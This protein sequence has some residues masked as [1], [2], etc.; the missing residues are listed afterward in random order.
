M[1]IIAIEIL[2]REIIGDPEMSGI[3]VFS[4]VCKLIYT[5][6]YLMVNSLCIKNGYSEC[7]FIF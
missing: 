4:Y 2:R 1:Y 3:H 6:V 7:L 5:Q